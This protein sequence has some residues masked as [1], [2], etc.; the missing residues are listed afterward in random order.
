VSR[1][2]AC[3]APGFPP[4]STIAAVAA[5]AVASAYAR[6]T[7]VQAHVKS[8]SYSSWKLDGRG[9]RVE[10][11]MSALDATAIAEGAPDTASADRLGAYL[12]RRLQLYSGGASCTVAGAP[13]QTAAAEGWVARAWR[14]DCPRPGEREIRESVLLPENPA[15]LHFARATLPDGRVV[16]RI[17][18]EA[19]RAWPLDG[20]GAG[21]RS[22]GGRGATT[23]SFARWISIGADHLLTGWDHLAFLAGLLL[24]AHSTREVATTL[25]AYALSTSI[26]LAAA[27]LGLV[28]PVSPA[29]GALVGFSVALAAAENS[30]LLSGRRSAIA[31][32]ATLLVGALATLAAWRP[33]AL[34]PL[35][36]GGLALLVPCRLGLLRAPGGAP[37]LRALLAFAFGIV[38]GLGFAPA[39][40]DLDLPSDRLVPAL[41]GFNLGIEAALVAA[42]AIA[43]PLFRLGGRLAG[44]PAE[45]TIEGVLAGALAGLGTFWF[46]S[47]A[48]R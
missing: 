40:A 23:A 28:A 27:G 21:R 31:L 48:F 14:V 38:H 8:L 3:L 45:R 7:S 35:A 47:R 25:A 20:E 16:E 34:G 17:L 32:G 36:L 18:G 41:L 22:T 4:W 30:W 11:R 39:L 12:A 9:A 13:E 6:P 24:L 37:R 10:A 29:V 42:A 46:V 5:M 2:R 44:A 1:A 26:A 19:D 43:W 15:H 33:G